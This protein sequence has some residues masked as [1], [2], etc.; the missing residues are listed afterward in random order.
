MFSQTI[1]STLPHPYSK[2]TAIVGTELMIIKS[3]KS[4][5]RD[6]KIV[7]HYLVHKTNN[8]KLTGEV[9]VNKYL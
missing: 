9:K 3:M 5:S 8:V 4:Y 6:G 7:K 2:D 1:Q